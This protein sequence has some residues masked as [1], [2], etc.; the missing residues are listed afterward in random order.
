MI[1]VPLGKDTL[2]VELL[3]VSRHGFW[4]LVQAEELFVPFDQF[5]WFRDASISEISNVSLP[6]SHHLYWSDLDIDLAVESLRH[7][8][9]FP[10]T[11]KSGV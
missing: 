10:L 11:S 8:E 4:L 5:P 1:S 3:N 2:E 9:R 7:P 6:S